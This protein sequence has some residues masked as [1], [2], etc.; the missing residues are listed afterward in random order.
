MIH[1]LKSYFCFVKLY[2]SNGTAFILLTIHKNN[3]FKNA[4]NKFI[5]L[6]KK[7]VII[8][9]YVPYSDYLVTFLIIISYNT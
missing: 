1:P 6:Y 8:R 5:E 4:D 3:T 2:V 9:T 7:K